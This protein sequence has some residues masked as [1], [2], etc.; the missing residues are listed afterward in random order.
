MIRFINK[1]IFKKIL[2]WR[3][4][5]FIPED[6]KIIAIVAP[7]TSWN[8][9]F[10]GIFT[11]SILKME[12]RV[13]FLGKEELFKIP[14]FGYILRK[15]GGFPV[16]RNKETNSVDSVV[17]IFNKKKNFFLALAPEG[18]RK[19]VDKLKTGFYYIALKAKV[20]ILLVGFDFK[21]KLVHF[22]EKLYPSGDIEKDMKIIITYFKKFQGKI[23]VNGLNHF[24]VWKDI[25]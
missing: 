22:G 1:L 11:R 10:V 5:G 20:P 23:P 9:L 4:E 14:L 6:K 17:E 19:K 8:D 18:T 15:I 16:A 25:W 21:K 3:I 2:G 12:N 24:K 13:K 7:H